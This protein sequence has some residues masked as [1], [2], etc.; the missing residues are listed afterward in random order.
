M[1]MEGRPSPKPPLPP[2]N[3]AGNRYAEISQSLS[4]TGILFRDKYL[5]NL[6]YSIGKRIKVSSTATSV[7]N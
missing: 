2:P 7:T 5:Q 6:I 1:W 4:P 3:N